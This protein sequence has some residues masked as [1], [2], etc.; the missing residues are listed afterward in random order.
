MFYAT[1]VDLATKQATVTV[2][3]PL[4]MAVTHGNLPM[5]QQLLT[6]GL[7]VDA[8]DLADNGSTPLIAAARLGRLEIMQELLS[9]G[10]QPNAQDFAG[11]S[12]LHAA[13]E[14]NDAEAVNALLQARAKV[15]IQNVDGVSPLHVAMEHGLLAMAEVLLQRGAAANLADNVGDTPL[16]YVVRVGVDTARAAELSRAMPV[17]GHT[18]AAAALKK[19]DVP[20]LP[21]FRP[22]YELAVRAGGKE[23]V[24][25]DD[26]E[27]PFAL[28]MSLVP[29][30][31]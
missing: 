11:L 31:R 1:A 25:N 17:D 18:G 7:R 20:L 12:A 2:H 27:T 28:A 23:D 10:A 14:R 9:S 5:L 29:G 6:A 19:G 22:L 21:E 24:A 3:T 13:V 15:N 30:A 8:R 16:H 26:G 4:H